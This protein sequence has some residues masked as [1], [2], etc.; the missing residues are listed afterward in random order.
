MTT[1]LKELHDRLLAQKPDDATHNTENCIHCNEALASELIPEGGDMS[2]T[3]TEDDLNAAVRE[4]VAAKQVEIDALKASQAETEVEARVAAAKAEADERVAAL[5]ADLDAATLR[6]DTAEKLHT[7]LVAYLDAEKARQDA[8][9]EAAARAESRLAVIKEVAS[10]KDDYIAANLDRWAALDE[11][12]FAALV[13]DWKLISAPAT[14]N[15]HATST[16]LPASTAMAAVREKEE[17]D[18]VAQL[19]RISRRVDIKSL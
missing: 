3:F 1:A 7:D 14:A 19:M 11:E 18:P 12:A 6:A 9:V 8:E 13:E 17:I 2:K 15:A 5:Q 10:F 4:A 16:Q